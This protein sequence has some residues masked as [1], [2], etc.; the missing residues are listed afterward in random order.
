M[1]RER[2]TER[3]RERERE[4]DWVAVGE[5]VAHARANDLCYLCWVL[6]FRCP[7]FLSYRAPECRQEQSDQQPETITGVQR[8]GYSW[9]HQVSELTGALHVIDL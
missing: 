3:E 8:W 4:R 6:R 9:T 1:Y 5:F 2:D 7:P